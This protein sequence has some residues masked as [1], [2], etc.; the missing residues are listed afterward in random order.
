MSNICSYIIW[1]MGAV[2]VL[3]RLCIKKSFSP[4]Y[5]ARL[6]RL[7][8]VKHGGNNGYSNLFILVKL[9]PLCNS[10]VAKLR[11]SSFENHNLLKKL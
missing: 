3:A 7:K 8:V 1:N 11:L 10:M 5:D 6:N 9:D 4:M 2:R